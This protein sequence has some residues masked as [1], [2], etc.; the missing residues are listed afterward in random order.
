MKV[1]DDKN[2]LVIGDDNGDSDR[3]NCDDDDDEGVCDGS[4]GPI[5]CSRESGRK[6]DNQEKYW[7]ASSWTGNQE[8]LK[9]K[10]IHYQ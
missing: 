10:Y 1:F 2:D 5:N 6:Q 7:S 8:L 9:N 4:I 3:E